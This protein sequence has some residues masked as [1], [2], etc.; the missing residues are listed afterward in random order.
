MLDSLTNILFGPEEIV[1]TIFKQAFLDRGHSAKERSRERAKKH[2]W[3][4]ISN[5][6]S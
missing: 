5:R 4:L 3:R 1:N 6:V 2:G